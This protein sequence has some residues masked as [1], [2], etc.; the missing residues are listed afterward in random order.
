MQSAPNNSRFRRPRRTDIKEDSYWTLIDSG[1]KP[2]F[3]TSS[4]LPPIDPFLP[5]LFTT[6]NYEHRLNPVLSVFGFVLLNPTFHHIAAILLSCPPYFCSTLTHPP[7]SPIK[8]DCLEKT[9]IELNFHRD[10][11]RNILK[12][13]TA[14][15]S[16][17]KLTALANIYRP[18][19]PPRNNPDQ[20]LDASAT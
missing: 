9:L 6:G 14:S 17:A 8:I 18:P 13:Q 12:K 19:P 16:S 15:G 1:W 3:S 10:R 7:Q 11:L 5:S 4:S 2:R 20:T